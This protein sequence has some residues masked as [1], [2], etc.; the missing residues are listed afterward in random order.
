MLLRFSFCRSE[1][2][3]EADGAAL[4]AVQKFVCRPAEVG[5]RA[6][7]WGASASAGPETHGEYL[8]DCKV[9]AT[10]GL[11]K[12]KDS[13]ILQSRVWEELK[14]RLEVST[15]LQRRIPR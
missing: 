14:A 12:G 4:R 10:A 15:I 7:V 2:H 1:L 13:A 5:A 11:S 8:P 3:R 9:K 6:L